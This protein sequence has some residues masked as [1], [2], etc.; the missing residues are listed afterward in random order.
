M[1]KKYKKT[2][3]QNGHRHIW[4]THTHIF[5]KPLARRPSIYTQS[6]PG[7]VHLK[8]YLKNTVQFIQQRNQQ[9]MKKHKPFHAMLAHNIAQMAPKLYWKTNEISSKSLKIASQIDAKSMKNRWSVGGTF[10]ERP[11]GAK[12]D[13][14]RHFGMPFGGHFTAKIEKRISKKACRIQSWKSI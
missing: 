9:L 4:H 1:P 3:F 8:M 2:I 5:V 7:R 12:R 10:L 13:P 14:G 11:L 6:R